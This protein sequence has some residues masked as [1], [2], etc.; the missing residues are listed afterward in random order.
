M[1]SR[2]RNPGLKERGVSNSGYG[3]GLSYGMRAGMPYVTGEKLCRH[4][5][6]NRPAAKRPARQLF[7]GL[8]K[9]CP[10]FCGQSFRVFAKNI[11]GD[12]IVISL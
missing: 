11:W 8:K 7:L 5:W 2:F 10:T 6:G 3:S 9:F 12:T 1:E 4:E